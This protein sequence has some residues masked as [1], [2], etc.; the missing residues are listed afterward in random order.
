MPKYRHGNMIYYSRMRAIIRDKIRQINELHSTYPNH[1]LSCVCGREVSLK[2]LR[3]SAY[4]RERIMRMVGTI[5]LWRRMDLGRN[6]PPK[7]GPG[8]GHKLI[9]PRGP[10]IFFRPK[11]SKV[12]TAEISALPASIGPTDA[13]CSD[14]ATPDPTTTAT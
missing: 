3:D 9:G 4:C 13:T 2:H 10:R 7:P 5:L 6:W 12:T 8:R 11:V 14:P 1:P